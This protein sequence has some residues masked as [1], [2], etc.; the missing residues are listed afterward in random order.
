MNIERFKYIKNGVQVPEY[1]AADL[2]Q[3]YERFNPTF[4]V[5]IIVGVGLIILSPIS[6]LVSNLY[7]GI[8]NEIGVV[9]LLLLVASA[10]FLFIISGTI[11]DSYQRL[12]KLGNYICSEKQKKEGKVIGAVAAFVWPLAAAIFLFLT[13]VY[14]YLNAWMIF[15]ITGILFG[16]FCSV[17]SIITEKNK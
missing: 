11:R 8:A 1:I 6:V 17:Y 5:T 7:G 16:I 12:L 3:R 4:Y 13:I 10:V 15:P 9:I 14:G 2:R